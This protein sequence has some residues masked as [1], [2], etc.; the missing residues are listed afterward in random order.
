MKI[1]KITSEQIAMLAAVVIGGI[2]AIVNPNQMES[3]FNTTIM[4]IVLIKLFW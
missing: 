1:E 2:F 3:A 4:A